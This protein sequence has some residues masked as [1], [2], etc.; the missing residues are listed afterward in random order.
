MAV[1]SIV[2]G[3]YSIKDIER[4]SGIKAHTLRIWEKRYGIIAPSRTETN[5]RY[6]TNEEL[7]KILNISILNNYGMKIS[8]IVGLSAEEL[9]QKVIEISSEEI[10]EDLQI[11]SLVISMVQVDEQR[12]ERILSNCTLRLG[13]E[14]TILNIVYPFFKKVGV[15]WQAGAINPAQEHFISNL[16]RQ[17][18]IVAI[19]GQGRNGKEGAKKFL[20]FLPEG[21]L[22]ELGLLFYNYLIQKSGHKV[23]YLGQSVPLADVLKVNE[24]NPADYIVTATMSMSDP[25]SVNELLQNLLDHFPNQK[26]ILSNRLGDE[27]EILKSERLVYNQSLPEFKAFLDTPV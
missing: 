16:I 13:F 2:M 21:E 27:S 5:I 14:Q 7:K 12:F 18:L 10:E 6:Y 22:H 19:D 1:E 26:I 8:K 17:K 25:G 23:I 15:L 4:I 9:H 24:Q 3:R 11:E 20:L